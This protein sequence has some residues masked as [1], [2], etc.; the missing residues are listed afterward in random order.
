M[1]QETFQAKEY[2]H[3]AIQ[4][5]THNSFYIEQEDFENEILNTQGEPHSI[6]ECHILIEKAIE[7]LELRGDNHSRFVKKTPSTNTEKVEIEEKE[8]LPS[9]LI[10]DGLGIIL[11]PEITSYAD[12]DNVVYAKTTQNILAN[13]EKNDVKALIIDM[14]NNGG[15]NMEGMIAGLGPLYNT[16]KIGKFIFKDNREHEWGYRDGRYVYK[17][18]GGVEESCIIENPLVLNKQRKIFIIIDDTVASS[19]E[20]VVISFLGQDNVTTIGQS[21]GGYT[22]GNQV[23]KL[24]DRSKII[25]ATS[26]TQDRQGKSYSKIVPDIEIV[27]GDI[28]KHIKTIL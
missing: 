3:K 16:S 11:M 27:D 1:L 21:T 23:F 24:E 28:L 18:E 9:G 2:L 10:E 12:K 8:A 17:H 15:G 14:R 26:I 19:A 25:L 13:F 7:M 4:I 5:I 6:S 22:T 20:M